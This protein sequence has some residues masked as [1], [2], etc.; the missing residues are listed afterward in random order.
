MRKNTE[1]Q[2]LTKNTEFN[3]ESQ[4]FSNLLDLTIYVLLAATFPGPCSAVFLL[5]FFFLKINLN[6]I[7]KKLTRNPS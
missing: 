7:E 5:F 4:L 6:T 2:N 3:E 1:I